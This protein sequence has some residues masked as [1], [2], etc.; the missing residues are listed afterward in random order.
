M[1]FL[2]PY[3]EYED[4]YLFDIQYPGFN[5][6]ANEH[7]NLIAKLLQVKDDYRRGEVKPAAILSFIVDDVIIGH[8]QNEDIKYFI[9]IK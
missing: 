5:L 2:I 8:F 7:R 3:F 1:G 4:K 6:H 9:Y